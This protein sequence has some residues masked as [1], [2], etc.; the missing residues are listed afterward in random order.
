MGSIKFDNV[1][2][3]VWFKLSSTELRDH[4]YE[5]FKQPCR[6]NIRKHFFVNA[7]SITGINYQ[8]MSSIA[9]R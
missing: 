4:D 1:D 6:P 7:L 3:N 8:Q 2:S 5:R 9:S